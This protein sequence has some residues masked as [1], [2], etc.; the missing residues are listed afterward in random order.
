MNEE[1]GQ[2]YRL[3]ES[4]FGPDITFKEPL[5]ARQINLKQ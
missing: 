2:I 3:Q 4:P 1:S 5:S